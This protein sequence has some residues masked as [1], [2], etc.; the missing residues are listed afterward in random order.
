MEGTARRRGLRFQLINSACYLFKGLVLNQTFPHHDIHNVP[1]RTRSRHLHEVAR[2]GNCRDVDQFPELPCGDIL[3][4]V[5]GSGLHLAVLD[6]INQPNRFLRLFRFRLLSSFRL[7]NIL[8]GTL[9]NLQIL[10]QRK[11]PCRILILRGKRFIFR[12]INAADDL[13]PG[14]LILCTLGREISFGIP[15]Q[16]SV[17]KP[18][19]I[20]EGRLPG[21]VGTDK[22]EVI[23]D[24]DFRI[25]DRSVVVHAHA[26]NLHS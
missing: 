21:I 4:A 24:P 15:F 12:F 23:I 8:L 16:L 7:L 5:K 6:G 17:E 13:N 26:F 19:G 9:V 3:R 1:E 22:K 2:L 11:A 20:E 14:V 18:Y 10:S 25:D